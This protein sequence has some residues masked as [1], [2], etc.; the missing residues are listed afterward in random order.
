MP[1]VTPIH[2]LPTEIWALARGYTRGDEPCTLAVLL[3]CYEDRT[4]RQ[5]ADDTGVDES[6]IKRLVKGFREVCSKHEE[7]RSA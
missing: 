3:R 2:Q 6:K 5:I 1:T 4:Y 7:R